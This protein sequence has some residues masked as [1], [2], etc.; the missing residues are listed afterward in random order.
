MCLQNSQDL[1]ELDENDDIF[2]CIFTGDE[3]WVYEYNLENKCASLVWLTPEELYLKKPGG[4]NQRP[5]STSSCLLM[6]SWCPF[7][8]SRNSQSAFQLPLYLTFFIC[9]DKQL[10]VQGVSKKKRKKKP[11][12]GIQQF[13]QQ[14]KNAGQTIAH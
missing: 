13:L 7:S 4:P 9:A 1:L 2:S 11:L 8:P 6:L 12:V 14:T 3:S 5:Q 10:L